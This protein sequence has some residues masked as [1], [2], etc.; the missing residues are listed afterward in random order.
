MGEKEYG[1]WLCAK[2]SSSI[3]SGILV[4]LVMAA[5][6]S[7]SDSFTAGLTLHDGGYTRSGCLVQLQCG[8]EFR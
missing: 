3:T 8:N 7:G 4:S 2:N 1:M 6:M 5:R